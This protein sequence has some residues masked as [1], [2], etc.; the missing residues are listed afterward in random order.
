MELEKV[1]FTRR[2]IEMKIITQNRNINK[3]NYVLN[4]I[5]RKEE[6]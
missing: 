4:K 6:K 5:F 1:Q 3:Y 2:K